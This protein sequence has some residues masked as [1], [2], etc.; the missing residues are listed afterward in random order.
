MY[1]ERLSIMW[2]SQLAFDRLANIVV[3]RVLVFLEDQIEMR[4]RAFGENL[5]ECLLMH[6]PWSIFASL[7][8]TQGAAEYRTALGSH[9][10][11]S[12]GTG[13]QQWKCKNIRTMLLRKEWVSIFGRNTGFRVSEIY[14]IRAAE[15][16]PPEINTAVHIFGRNKDFRVTR[17]YKKFVL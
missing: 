6:G 1:L 13:A 3:A 10:I 8:S 9:A 17:K 11:C 7:S 14:I 12:C 4:V 2:G 16:Y 15:I 5:S